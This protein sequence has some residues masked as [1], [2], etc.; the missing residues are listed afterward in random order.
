MKECLK[1]LE[2]ELITLQAGSLGKLVFM[3]RAILLL[4]CEMFI[5][6]RLKLISELPCSKERTQG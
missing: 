4:Q 5:F 1:I 3:H 6:K 2:M